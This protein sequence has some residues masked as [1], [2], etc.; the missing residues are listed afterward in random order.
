MY[1]MHNKGKS[2]I[3]ER[4]I[5]T[6]KN[7]IYKSMISISKNVYLDKLNNKV[8]TYNNTYHR[9]IKITPVDVKSSTYINWK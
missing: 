1:S 3:G 6:L 8:N 9:T 4:F 2:L 7:K 5:R